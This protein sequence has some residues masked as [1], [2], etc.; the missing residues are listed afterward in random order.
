MTL[1]PE[2]QGEWLNVRSTKLG[3]AT[4]VLVALL[5][6]GVVIIYYVTRP[7]SDLLRLQECLDECFEQYGESAGF[8]QCADVC[9]EVYQNGSR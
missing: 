8:L 7:P 5:A 4:L 2:G 1:E 6:I 9:G 3:A